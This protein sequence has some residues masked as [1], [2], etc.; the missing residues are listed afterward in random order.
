MYEVYVALEGLHTEAWR[1]VNAVH[2]HDE[3][4][5]LV[6][7]MPDDESWQFTPGQLVECE[8]CVLTGKGAPTDKEVLAARR[9]VTPASL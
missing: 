6:G 7:N 8:R 5:R 3:V 4:F 2:V 1:A 9:A